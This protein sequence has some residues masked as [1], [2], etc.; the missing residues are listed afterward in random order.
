MQYADIGTISH[1]TMRAEDLINPFALTLEALAKINNVEAEHAPL[2]KEAFDL[3]YDAEEDCYR[4]EDA[5]DDV[6]ESLFDALNEFAPPYCYFGAHPGDG[7]D[8]GF[9][10]CEDFQQYMRDSDVL[11]VSDTSEIPDDYIGEVLH[12]NER[13][14]ATLYVTDEGSTD[15]REIWSIV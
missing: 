9:W 11:Q 3:E 4:D 10:P 1:G 8:Y 14:N 15:L 2:I 12:V 7:A 5:A 6:L 13:G